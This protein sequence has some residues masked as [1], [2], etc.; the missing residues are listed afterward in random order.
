MRKKL[1][2]EMVEIKEVKASDF[3]VA[4]IVRRRKHLTDVRF[5][6]NRF[7]IQITAE[8]NGILVVQDRIEGI[9]LMDSMFGD[10][11]PV[12][13]ENVIRSTSKQEVVSEITTEAEKY[14]IFKGTCWRE[15]GEPSYNVVT[16]GYGK[17]SRTG[18]FVEYGSNIKVPK[19]NRFNADQRKDAL[20]RARELACEQSAQSPIWQDCNIE[21]VN[22]TFMHNIT[23]KS[24]NQPTI[25]IVGGKA[26]DQSFKAV[27]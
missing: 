8:K 26:N 4:F 10:A 11:E 13:A 12:S 18:I 21:V 2:S 24:Q 22:E 16:L 27:L 9:F 1:A 15:V 7:W 23:D 20:I 3:P 6:D 14:V 19:E 5:Y 25:V 17:D